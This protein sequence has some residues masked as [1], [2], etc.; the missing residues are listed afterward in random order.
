MIVVVNPSN[1]AGQS[2]KGLHAYCAHDPDRAQTSERVSWIDSRNIAAN[3]HEQ[4]WKIMA[5]TAKAQNDIKRSAGIRPGKAPKDG[6]VM[7]VVLSF[8]RDEPSDRETVQAAADE[9]LS[10]FGVD[11]ARMR[12]KNKPSRRQFADEHQVM[13]YAHKDTDHTH[14]HLMINRVH[15]ETGIVLPSNNDRLKA[16]KWALEFSKRHGTDQKTPAREENAELRAQG[17]YV[18]G[19]RRKSR[20]AYEQEKELQKAAANDN[21]LSKVIEQQ[22]AKDAALSLRGR[23]MQAMHDRA[24]DQLVSAHKERKAALARDLQRRS[25]AAHADVREAYRPKWRKLRQDQE[26][27]RATFAE[28]EKSFFGRTANMAK[29]TGELIRDGRSGVIG[30]TF[31][32]LSNAGDRQAYFEKA[33]ERSR[34]ALQRQQA[35]EVRSAVQEL[36]TAQD[37]KL[38]NNRAVFLEER[39][40]LSLIQKRDAQKLQDDWKDRSAEKRA[41]LSSAADRAKA[42]EADR[43]TTPRNKLDPAAAA[44]LS[45]YL[46]EFDQ[47][48][49]SAGRSIEQNNQRD[50]DIAD[51]D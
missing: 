8:D 49:D 14:V 43:T 41:T 33:Q 13:M 27:E 9:F 32:I 35:K 3:D 30:R 50:R 1:S 2:F 21:D 39:A 44:A 16:Q 42:I 25:N 22:K 18:K 31:R 17:E 38:A 48:A 40:R 7:H 28:L 46:T 36:R 47:V 20:N 24:R 12:S 4:G 10:Q 5:A 26:S 51:D 34:I 19:E 6:A 45:R 37:R 29:L 15:P 23:N 11:P